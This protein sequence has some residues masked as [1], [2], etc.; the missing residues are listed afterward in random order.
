MRRQLFPLGVLVEFVVLGD[1][2]DRLQE[3][4]ALALAP[5]RQR[6]V[7]NLQIDVRHHQTFVKEELDP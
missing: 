7:R 3:I 6:P 5:R 2:L 1:R 4:R